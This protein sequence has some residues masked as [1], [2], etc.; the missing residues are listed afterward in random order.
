MEL[1][2]KI[3]EHT[4][5]LMIQFGIR[6]VTMDDISRDL[7]I[8]KKTIYQYFKDKKDLV[9]SIVREHIDE[10]INHFRRAM[11][12]GENSIHALIIVSQCLRDSLKDIKANIMHE[13]HRFYPDA[14]MMF[15]DFKVNVMKESLISVIRR[16]QQEGHFRPEI[17]AELM[18]SL[19][20]EQV[21]IFM[22]NKDLL[23]RDQISL[24]EVQYQLFDHFIHGLFTLEGYQLFNQYNINNN[25]N[26]K[27]TQ[28][29]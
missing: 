7:G 20:I 5:N 13:L 3:I 19:R 17:N 23:P 25:Q 18:A 28:K 15:E 2:D 21:Q 26:E 14:W 22:M 11:S 1:R 4:G 6:T 27:L 29:N 8:S 10:D 16:G 24:G 12:E 9:N